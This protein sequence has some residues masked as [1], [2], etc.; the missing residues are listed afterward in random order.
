MTQIEER[1]AAGAAETVE[2]WLAA[3]NGALEKGDTAAVSELFLET[4]FWRDLVA[5]TWNLT[6]VGKPG[7]MTWRLAAPP[8]HS[9]PHGFRTAEAAT[10]TEG[11]IEALIAFETDVGRGN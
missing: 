4:S 11:V 3:F 1:P 8:A 5:L 6:T 10:E 7:G 9:R 2:R